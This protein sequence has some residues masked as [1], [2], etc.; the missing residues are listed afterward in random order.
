MTNGVSRH[1][2]APMHQLASHHYLAGRMNEA[3]DALEKAIALDLNNPEYHVTLGIAHSMN[4]SLILA[5][6]SFQEAVRL[7]PR[8]LNARYNF[9]LCLL[10]LGQSKSAVGEFRRILKKQAGNTGAL[11]H[12]GL[13]YRRGFFEGCTIFQAACSATECWWCK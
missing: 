2:L 13:S 7:K 3:M 11:L 10:N 4:N 8:N 5:K 6:L 1:T 9:A 12:L